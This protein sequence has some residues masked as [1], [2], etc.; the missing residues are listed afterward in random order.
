L[1]QPFISGL[2]RPYFVATLDAPSVIVYVTNKRPIH[3]EGRR[4]VAV[5]RL[6]QQFD[7]HRSAAAA[8][9]SAGQRIP[10]SCIVPGNPP[11]PILMTD[12]KMTRAT[13]KFTDSNVWDRAVYVPRARQ[14]VKCFSCESLFLELREPPTV[15]DGF[16]TQWFGHD[17]GQRMQNRGVVLEQAAYDAL[18]CHVGMK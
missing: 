3:R 7:S 17:P 12:P 14:C 2:C 9:Q 8:Y 4:L 1:A 6:D 11:L 10:Y 15:D 13:A 5:L 16:W 18:L